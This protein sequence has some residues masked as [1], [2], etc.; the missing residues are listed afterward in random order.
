LRNEVLGKDKIMFSLVER[1]KSSEARISIFSGAEQKMKGFEERQLKD[2]K[3]IADLEYALS[4]QV[5][6]YRSE[7]QELEKKFD[8]VTENFNVEQTKHEIYDMEWL[9]VQKM[10]K[11]F[12]KPKR[13]ATTLLRN[14][15][16]IWRI[17]LLRLVHSP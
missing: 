3:H 17:V 6:L 7:V 8:E 16:R 15:L 10:L 5:E 11:S 13:N 2:A 9:M 4:T 12:I 1:L 14:V